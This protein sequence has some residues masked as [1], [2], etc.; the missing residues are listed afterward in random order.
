MNGE[1]NPC[2]T[3]SL[4]THFEETR[5]ALFGDAHGIEILLSIAHAIQ[6]SRNTLQMKPHLCNIRVITS[7][8]VI[9][10]LSTL[11]VLLYFM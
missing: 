4:H 7:L 3:L 9:I 2:P 1:G 10:S 6:S 8:D 11:L 5:G